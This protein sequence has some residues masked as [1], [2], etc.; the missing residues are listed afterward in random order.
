M[1]FC[2]QIFKH[3]DTHK[4]TMS[5]FEVKNKETLNYRIN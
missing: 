1:L 4:T 5:I 3:L 2:L